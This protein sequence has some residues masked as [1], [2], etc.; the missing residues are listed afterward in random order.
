MRAGETSAE[1][2]TTKGEETLSKSTQSTEMRVH[3][4]ITY[5]VWK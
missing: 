5:T 3:T 4:Y 2:L 1:C